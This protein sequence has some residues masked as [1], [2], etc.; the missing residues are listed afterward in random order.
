MTA[1]D[2]GKTPPMPADKVELLPLPEPAFI[3]M[4]IPYYTAEQVRACV[5]TN[6]E[7]LRA[8]VERLTFEM[9]CLQQQYDERTAYAIVHRG[10]ALACSDAVRSAYSDEYHRAERLAEALR[11]AQPFIG[12]AGS[13]PEL[14]AKID[15]L[16]NPTAAQ[17]GDHG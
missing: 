17:E 5:E 7:A 16:L 11:E 8:K 9:G 2:W 10:A 12:W 13:Y 15:A 1:A 3:G 14:H 4:S 6:T